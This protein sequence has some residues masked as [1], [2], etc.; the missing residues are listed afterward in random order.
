MRKAE[1]V[2]CPKRTGYTHHP[3]HA[4]V[5]VALRT[6]RASVYPRSADTCARLA[7]R[8]DEGPRAHERSRG[9]TA[10]VRAL[11]VGSTNREPLRE[12]RHFVESSLISR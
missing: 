10:V 3:D 8:S 11:L 5:N 7:R 9:L 1:P 2:R 6:F 4:H 12:L